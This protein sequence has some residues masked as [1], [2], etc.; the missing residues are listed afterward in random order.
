MTVRTLIRPCGDSVTEGHL[1]CIVDQLEIQVCFVD[2]MP[3]YFF[4]MS[5]LLVYFY[6]RFVVKTVA[7]TYNY[8]LNIST[9][10][11]LAVSRR[12]AENTCSEIVLWYPELILKI[13]GIIGKL[14]GLFTLFHIC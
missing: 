4:L 2:S 12:S 11:A 5:Y 10:N 3:K 14:F 7:K 13:T 6:F 8:R 1:K 9:G